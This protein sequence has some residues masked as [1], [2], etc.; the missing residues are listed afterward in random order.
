MNGQYRSYNYRCTFEALGQDFY[1]EVTVDDMAS[2]KDGFWVTPCW[3]FTVHAGSHYFYNAP[4][5]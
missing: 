2:I 3:N 4:H 1:K 5:D